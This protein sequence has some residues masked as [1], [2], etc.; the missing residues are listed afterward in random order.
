MQGGNQI[1]IAGIK[2]NLKQRSLK[3]MCNIVGRLDHSFLGS[4]FGFFPHLL[5]LN[6]S[7]PVTLR[8]HIL[9]N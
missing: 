8:Y 4:C 1:E 7:V 9:I 3:C 6:P 5:H 2:L